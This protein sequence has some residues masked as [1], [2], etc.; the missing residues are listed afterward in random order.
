MEA[1]TKIAFGVV[2][3][4]ALLLVGYIAYSEFSR[5]RDME[6]GAA[7][8]DQMVHGPGA[9]T[10][11]DVWVDA[12]PKRPAPLVDSQR[13]LL[14]GDQRCVGGVVVVVAGSTY[15]Q[16]GTVGDPVRCSGRYADRPIR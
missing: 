3:A 15:T 9:V 7:M 1:S 5:N 8:F 12:P 4:A 6:Q 11:A 14:A 16:L 2:A 13:R 10:Q